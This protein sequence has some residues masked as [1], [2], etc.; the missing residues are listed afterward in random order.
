MLNLMRASHVAN[1]S[2]HTEIEGRYWTWK[3]PT[4]ITPNICKNMGV[5][6]F[7]NIV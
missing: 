1:V 4:I 7:L 5:K 6:P 3:I 2:R